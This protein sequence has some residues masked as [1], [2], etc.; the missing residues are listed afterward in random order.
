MS[1]SIITLALCLILLSGCETTPPPADAR[2]VQRPSKLFKFDRLR[3]GVLPG[4]LVVQGRVIRKR[5]FYGR[6]PGHIH[7]EAFAKGTSLGWQDAR[8]RRLSP[9]PFAKSPFKVRFPFDPSG[10]D[11]VRVSYDPATETHERGPGTAS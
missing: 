4:Q 8:W 9:K 1:R 6:I 7:V 11:E 3:A 10:V 5:R 2:I